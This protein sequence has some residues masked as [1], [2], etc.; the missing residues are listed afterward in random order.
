MKSPRICLGVPLKR[1][2]IQQ[3]QVLRE[4]LAVHPRS[5]G[6][7]ASGSGRIR[8]LRKKFEQVE[9]QI[10]DVTRVN[11][12][13]APEDCRGCHRSKP[14]KAAE[15]DAAQPFDGVGLSPRQWRRCRSGKPRRR[16][17]SEGL[18]PSGTPEHAR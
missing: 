14:R 5:Y 1:C 13:Q 16:E 6:A 12:E 15:S 10:D 3:V 7:G 8:N 4:E 18:P 2:V 11:F 17:L 9:L